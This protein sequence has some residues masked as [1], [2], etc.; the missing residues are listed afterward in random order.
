[1][2]I[3]TR[4]I[5][6]QHAG[7]TYEGMLA[8]DDSVEGPRPGVAI[9]HA[10]A[11]RTEFEQ[12]KAVALAQ[13]GYAGFA[14]DVF[15]KGVR[16]DGKEQCSAL[17]APFLED[18]PVL[19]ALAKLGLEVMGQQPE[20]DAGCTAAIGFCFGGLTVLDLA[21]SG[22][23]VR[24]VVSFHGLFNPPG[25]TAGRP[26]NAKVLCLHGYDDPMVPPDSVLALASEL[27]AAGADWQLHAYGN[28]VHA[29]TNPAAND[30]DFGAVYQAD[31]DRRSWLALTNFLDEVLA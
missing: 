2:S 30:P 19:Q 11:G 14:L 26:I 24:A 4:M 28:T 9:A 29:F 12:D 27:S 22:A 1:M 15:G 21:R 17:I 20:V 13:L 6:Y 23:D 3:Q 8:W 25:N 18:R 31:A 16:G 5:E 7:N 10:W